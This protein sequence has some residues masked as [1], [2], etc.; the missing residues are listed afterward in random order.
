MGAFENPDLHASAAARLA[1]DSASSAAIPQYQTNFQFGELRLVCL[2]HGLA[3]YCLP[4][5]LRYGC[6][7]FLRVASRQA[8]NF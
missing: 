2:W 7:A 5:V 4:A 8:A 3:A 6:S 1:C